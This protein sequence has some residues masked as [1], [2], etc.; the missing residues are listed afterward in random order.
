LAFCTAF[1]S[2]LVGEETDEVRPEGI[3]L[4]NRSKIK[5]SSLAI[6][7]TTVSLI[8]IRYTTFEARFRINKFFLQHVE[9]NIFNEIF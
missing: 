8:L 4:W 3:D 9:E 5:V 6:G 7:D 2:T 1:C